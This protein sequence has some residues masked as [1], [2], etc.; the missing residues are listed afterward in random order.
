MAGPEFYLFTVNLEDVVGTIF[1][2]RK[3]VM[4]FFEAPTLL[5]KDILST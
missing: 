4:A 2:L 5:L 1:T 3:G